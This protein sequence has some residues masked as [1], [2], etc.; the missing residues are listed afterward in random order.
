MSDHAIDVT[1]ETFAS[2]VLERS[3]A[4]PVVVDLWAPWCGPCRALGPVLEK[5]AAEANGAFDLVKINVDENP[6]SA[7]RLGARSIPLVIAFRDG[8]AVSSFVGAQPESAVR[9]FVTAL[10]PSEEDRM[11]NDA[12][13]AI[14]QQRLAD[15]EAILRAALDSNPRHAGARLLL[16]RLLGDTDRTGE[17]L[18]VLAKADPTPEVEQLRSAL[19]IAVSGE[20]DLDGLRARFE[21]GDLSAAVALASGLNAGGETEQALEILLAAVRG[22]PR[23]KECAAR[24]AM[25]DL[26]NVLGG[27]DPLVRRYR[28]EL[29]RALF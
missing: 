7:S 17:A 3:A 2:A 4:V 23:P 14:A 13:R 11:V 21:A 8:Q 19:R 22:D 24:A 12:R 27:G 5:V 25:L 15:G 26:F 29:A 16:A 28:S 9:R 18:E 6:V 20:A 10:L 1:D